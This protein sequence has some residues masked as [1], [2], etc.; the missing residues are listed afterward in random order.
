MEQVK[1]NRYNNFFIMLY[2]I[3]KIKIKVGVC[4]PNIIIFLVFLN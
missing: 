2:Y 4:H 1:F 3:I